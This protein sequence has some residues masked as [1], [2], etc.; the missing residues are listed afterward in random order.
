VIIGR[1]N[2]LDRAISF[3]GGVQKLADAIGVQQSAISN[4][5][6][7]SR[8]SPELA[9]AIHR[10]TNGQVSRESL[11]WPDRDLGDSPASVITPVKPKPP[12]S[13]GAKTRIPQKVA[14]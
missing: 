14:A 4:A 6:K 11:V 3:M 7:R 10:A 13:G 5:R 8:V 9:D 12:K 2:A 1:M